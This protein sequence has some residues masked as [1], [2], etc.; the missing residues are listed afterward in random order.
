MGSRIVFQDLAEFPELAV[1]RADTTYNKTGM[2]RVMRPEIDLAAC[3]RCGVCWKFCP[4]MAVDISGGAPVID[5]EFCKGC[6]VCAEE[7]PRKCIRLVAEE[8]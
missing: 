7:C 1:A 3:S 2:W 5:Y 6:G 4:D 8:K